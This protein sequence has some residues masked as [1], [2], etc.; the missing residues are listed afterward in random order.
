MAIETHV[1]DGSAWRKAK[2]IH[3]HDGTA[4]RN[5]KEAWC[6]DGTAWR[7]VFERVAGEWVTL[8]TTSATTIT[9]LTAQGG[10]PVLLDGGTA[11]ATDRVKKW[12]GS[13]WSG[14][15]SAPSSPQGIATNYA[16]TL[17]ALCG[18]TLY[19]W[20]GSTWSSIGSVGGDRINATPAAFSYIYFIG[21]SSFGYWDGSSLT[22][23][24]TTYPATSIRAFFKTLTDTYI[25]GTVNGVESAY[26]WSGSSTGWKTHGT[27]SL[28]S[29]P[30]SICEIG[31]SSYQN[32]I[33]D[34]QV[35]STVEGGS[36]SALGG[37]TSD[38]THSLARSHGSLYAAGDDGQIYKRVGSTWEEF[39][40]PFASG[41]G[42]GLFY[43]PFGDVLYSFSDTEVR[44]WVGS[45]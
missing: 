45:L 28:G 33:Q 43:D 8:G 4:W 39:G 6:H 20:T 2:E 18:S 34:D 31:P 14:I 37:P 30:V 13:S 9:D 25:I 1:H 19:Q 15:G 35:Y 26:R 29:G 12:D 40:E 7:K 32:Y 38:S 10:Y 16:G 36:Y 21:D 22:Y 3:V 44:Q 5:L 41:A 17:C 11:T 23:F 24:T 27:P 42:F